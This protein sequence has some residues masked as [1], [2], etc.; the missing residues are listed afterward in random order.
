MKK[1]KRKIISEIRTSIWEEYPDIDLLFMDPV[2][3]DK[4]ILGVIEGKA[5]VPAVAYDLD[6]V[7]KINMDMGMDR[8]GAVEYYEYNQVD[9]YKGPHTPVFIN[10][11]KVKNKNKSKRRVK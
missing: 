4:A 8:D 1:M 5:H 11:Q 3:Y 9:A 2:D 7:I 10:I 6:K